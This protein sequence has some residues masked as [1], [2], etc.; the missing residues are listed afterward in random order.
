MFSKAKKFW[1][2]AKRELIDPYAKKFGKGKMAQFVKGD[3][4]AKHQNS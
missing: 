3:D 1:S 4:N 2:H